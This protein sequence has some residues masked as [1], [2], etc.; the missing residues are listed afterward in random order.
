M[1]HPFRS[2]RATTVAAPTF[3]A[4]S[5][6]GVRHTGRMRSEGPRVGLACKSQAGRSKGGRGGCLAE[7]QGRARGAHARA[8]MAVRQGMGRR[9]RKGRPGSHR[10]LSAKTGRERTGKVG[11]NIFDGYV[12]ISTVP[13]SSA[14][15]SR[16]CAHDGRSAPHSPSPSVRRPPPGGRALA[17]GT[18]GCGRARRSWKIRDRRRSA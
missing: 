17:H 13:R 11:C 6:R 8:G 5:A 15:T 12:W 10:S 18:S 2:L 9:R 14:A 3:A 7:R 4:K 16:P 1:W